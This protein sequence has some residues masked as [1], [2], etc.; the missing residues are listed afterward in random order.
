MR[1]FFLS[2]LLVSSAFSLEDKSQKE[3]KPKEIIIE[4]TKEKSKLLQL[5]TGKPVVL[6]HREPVLFPDGRVAEVHYF[7]HKRVLPDE[8]RRASVGI[9]LM[10]ETD[11]EIFVLHQDL[12]SDGKETLSTGETAG[13]AVK[14]L[15]LVYDDQITVEISPK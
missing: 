3:V 15:K 4:S 1:F 11:R 10:S 7:S 9:R 6:H 8:P 13:Y 14:L 5:E 2:L 12:T